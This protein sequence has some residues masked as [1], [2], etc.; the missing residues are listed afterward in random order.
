MANPFL[1]R[2]SIERL[3]QEG[4]E[5]TGLK[6]VLG[7]WN[8]SAIGL[9]GI[10]G[11]G[12]FVLTGTAAATK[13]GPAVLLSFLIA[14]LASA[15]AALCYAE[16]SGMIPV[17][18]SAYTYSYAVLG[19]FAA[20]IIGWDLLLEYALVVG[21]VA[22][23]W[24]G[25]L[26]SILEQIGVHLPTW[27]K[28]ASGTG[29]GHVFDLFA[30]LISLGIAGLLSIGM[31]WGSRFNSLMVSIKLGI[32]LLIIGVGSF[33]V[34]PGNWHPF[35]P[36]GFS[37]VMSG[38][39]LV[40]FAVFGYDTLTTAAE[41]AK[42]PQRDLPRAVVVSLA[43]ALILYVGMSL[44]LTGIV[45]YPTLD[46]AAPAAKA[47]SDIGLGWA[48][49]IISVAAVTG[50]T[51]VL[52]SFMLAGS[53]I[54][55]SMSRDGLLPGW[56]SHV[57][58]KY[59]TPAR[60]TW[61]IGIVT[62]MIAGFTPIKKVAELANI[63]TLFAFVVICSSVI[64]LRKRRPDLERSFRTPLVPLIPL[65]GIGFSVWLM[66]SLPG[67]TWVRFGIWLL[68]GVLIYLIYGRRKSKLAQEQ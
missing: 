20:W 23:G 18:G 7:L 27:A 10:V 25:Y 64:L 56:F 61:I 54:W 65:I 45:E 17:A 1:R 42:N 47:F 63:G 2:K 26:Q 62:A 31:E 21:V 22:I 19:E 43:V 39:A 50:I 4:L 14:G 24:S 9:G 60:P 38:A 12:I 35:M 53:R 52:F 51:S 49:L 32:I 41:E 55:F 57:H 37:G 59:K 3:Q 13:A 6:R 67:I 8:L 44:V 66:M 29:K 33:Y 11:V 36:F 58:P 15:A 5:Q 30:S 28:G 34:D 68:V 46:N 16:F 40:F 48:T